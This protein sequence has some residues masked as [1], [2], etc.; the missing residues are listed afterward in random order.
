MT[1]GGTEVVAAE[2]KDAVASLK[3]GPEVR[4]E[5]GWQPLVAE[6]TR[7]PGAA[8]LEVFWESKGFHSEPL[9]HDRLRHRPDRAPA[10]LASDAAA[11]RGRFLVEERNCFAC[12]RPDEKDRIAAG[13]TGRQAPDLS[14]AGERM[15]A[16]WMY[17]WLEAPEKMRPGAVMPRLFTEGATGRAERYAVARYLA[18]RSAG[19]GSSPTGWETRLADRPC[20]SAS[21]APACHSFSREYLGSKTTSGRLAAYLRDPLAIDP[22][23]RMPNLLLTKEEA[24]EDLARYLCRDG[25]EMKLPEPP[26]KELAHRFAFRG[27][28]DGAVEL[29]AFQKLKADA[30]LLKLGQRVVIARGCNNCHTIEAGRQAV[31]VGASINLLRR[32]EKTRGPR[33]AVPGPDPREVSTGMPWFALQ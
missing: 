33:S 27:I 8:R 24:L 19:F 7:L 12:H 15:Y 28:E 18:P 1:I 6:F 30:Q 5:S 3:T 14:K 4:L 21:V 17:R 22:S 16:G 31:R 13:L 29:A 32:S 2:V 26:A 11:D 10:R 9:P 25:A 23:G 20:S